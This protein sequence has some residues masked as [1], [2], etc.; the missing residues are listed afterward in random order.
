MHGIRSS[1]GAAA[2][3]HKHIYRFVDRKKLKRLEMLSIYIIMNDCGR[4][5]RG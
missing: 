3:A 1:S 4:A 5:P 2:T